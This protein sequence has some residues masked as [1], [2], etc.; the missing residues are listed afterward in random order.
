MILL[1]ALAAAVGFL[2]GARTFA[3]VAMIAF[4]ATYG[5]LDLSGTGL[6]WLGNVAP[7]AILILLAMGELYGDKQ[8]QAGDRTVW[9]AWLGRILVGALAG[10]VLVLGSAMPA[11]GLAGAVAGAVGA[12]VG[13]F[14]TF[15]ARAGLIERQGP[16]A[17]A[18]IEDAF[19]ILGTAAII[20]AVA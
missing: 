18:L 12:A 13:T 9:F 4:A 11:S 19:V 6:A 15:R 3:P 7:T 2:T 8:P 17:G 5:W 14:V 16:I 1:L 10:A 20:L